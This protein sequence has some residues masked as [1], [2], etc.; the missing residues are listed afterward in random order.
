MKFQRSLLS[1]ALGLAFTMG[2][3]FAVELTAGTLRA[4]S[5]PV[6]MPNTQSDDMPTYKPPKRFLRG[7]RLDGG[8][9]GRG[10]SRGGGM[11]EGPVVLVLAPKDHVGLT[12]HAQPSLYWFLSQLTSSPLEFILIR[13]A[14]LTPETQA[15]DGKP[16]LQ[17]QLTPP[18]KAGIQRV[19]LAAHQVELLT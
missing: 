8:T 16:I 19:D 6:L 2:V 12:T 15:D 4:E 10:T 9:S 14:S 18:L 7:P 17:I 13:R 3:T 1:L 5:P 11:G